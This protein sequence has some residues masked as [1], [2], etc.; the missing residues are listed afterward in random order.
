M[1]D[2]DYENNRKQELEQFA[3]H[4]F[5]TKLSVRKVLFDDLTLA[6]N[7]SMTVF[8]TRDNAIYAAIESSHDDVVRLGDIE[9]LIKHAGF[10]PSHYLAPN[11]HTNYFVQR[12]YNIFASVY[13]GRHNWTED[14]EQYY[15]LLV[16]YS[17]GLVRLGTLL[18]PVRR[19]NT[20]GNNWQ[21][22]YEPS[23]KLMTQ[24]N[25]HETV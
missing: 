12:A 5:A 22:I 3:A 11:G 19:F 1:S 2:P 18:G 14:Q 8:S 23:K 10:S 4:H 21:V 9:R 25:T 24:R 17:P 13:P 16:P 15:Q 20:F 6:E 7:V